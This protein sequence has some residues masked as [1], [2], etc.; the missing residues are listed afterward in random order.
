MTKNSNYDKALET[1]SSM[2]YLF[3]IC[4]AVMAVLIITKTAVMCFLMAR[5]ASINFHN[6]MFTKITNAS[7]EFF[8]SRFVGNILNRFS[9]DLLYLDERVT[10]SWFFIFEGFIEI[11]GIAILMTTVNVTFLICSVIFV[12]ALF[13]TTLF[14]LKVTNTLKRVEIST[15]SPLIGHINATFE[16]LSTVKVAQ[17]EDI[18]QK[19]FDRHQD[20]YTS[21]S[22]VYM[23]CFRAFGFVVHIYSSLFLAFIV[24]YFLFI[25]NDADIGNVGLVITQAILFIRTKETAFRKFAKLDNE[26]TAVERIIEYTKQKQE[27]KQGMAVEKWPKFGQIKYENVNFAYDTKHILHNLNF[28]INSNE[29]IAVVGRTGAGKTSLISTLLRLYKTEG[30][31]FIDDVDIA[32][33]L[34][35]L[36]RENILVVP[37]DPF[38]FTGTIRENIDLNGI[39]SDD[40]IWEVMA[41]VGLK[42]RFST[43]E[44]KISNS[45]AELS[46]GQQQLICL[47]RGIIRKNKIAVFD[48]VTANVDSETEDTIHRIIQENFDSCTVIM[49]THKLRF[50]QEC[51]KIMVIDR[52]NV[53]EFDRFQKLLKDTSGLF[54][55][56]FNPTK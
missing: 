16:G 9:E 7:M 32:T 21:A 26:M 8:D 45:D 24:V 30:K 42:N 40:E 41:K 19:E 10:Y 2:F 27:N 53:A 36:L 48:E 23:C 35:D 34:L 52:G 33:L 44:D 13:L 4:T 55:N 37:Q 12:V 29:K 15:H 3:P 46:V 28:T 25:D 18:L 49:I 39:Y 56:M 50:V 6:F 47:A 43:L 1:R 54:Y 14:Y 31:I 20:L 5:K 38:L 22:I 51:D 11:I 17:V